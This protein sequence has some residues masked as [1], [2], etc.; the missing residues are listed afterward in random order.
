MMSRVWLS[1]GGDV[2]RDE[3]LAVTKTHDDRRPVSDGND[4]V[5]IV[6]RDEHEREEAAQVA[7][8]TPHRVLQTVALHLA[9]DEVRDDL[10]VRLGDERVPFFLQLVLQVEVVL[11]DP[12][13]DDNDAPGT[14]TMGMGVFLGGPTVRRPARMA[15]AVIALERLR[16]DDVLEV[17]QLACA[18]A[19][20]D[21]AVAHDGDAR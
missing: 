21:G 5:R 11:D 8:R 10:G 12:V 6:G 14:V 18:A 19:Q 16:G 20:L 7:Q 4:L 15:D 9:L 17:R 2:G 3:E 13:V 1:T